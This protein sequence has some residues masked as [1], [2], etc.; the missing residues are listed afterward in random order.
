MVKTVFGLKWIGSKRRIKA[1]IA[2]PNRD[3]EIISVQVD[4][5][6][7][8]H[9]KKTYIIN[10]D[11]IYFYKKTPLLIYHH[12]NAV[13]LRLRTDGMV[14]NSMRS[15]EIS[16]VLETNIIKQ[17]IE[18]GGNATDWLLYAVLGTGIIALVNLLVGL[19]VIKVGG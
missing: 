6:K 19:G 9:N 2:Y 3:A 17:I 7:F 16:K 14:E 11:A 8:R 10:E 1:L 18:A 15:E 12:S 4:E 13:P 5:N